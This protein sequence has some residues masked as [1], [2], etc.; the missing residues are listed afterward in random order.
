MKP[1]STS[2][3]RWTGTMS[4]S[5][6]LSN[7]MHR[8]LAWLSKSRRFLCSVP[9]ESARPI[10]LSLWLAAHFWT[11]WK[12]GCY[13]NWIPIMTIILYNL[14][15]LPPPPP[16]SHKCTSASQSCSST[17]L[18]RM[19]C[20]W[21]RHPSPLAT[22]LAGSYTMRFLSLGIRWR[23]RLC[24][25]I[26]HAHPGTLWS[27]NACIASHYSGHATRSLGWVELP[28]GPRCTYWRIITNARE[29]YT[30]AAADSVCCARVSSEIMSLITVETAPFFCACP[31]YGFFRHN[32]RSKAQF[33]RDL[34][35]VWIPRLKPL[36]QDKILWVI[37]RPAVALVSHMQIAQQRQIF[38]A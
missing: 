12:T 19:C 30:V 10:F 2:V 37:V 23:Q 8:T 9:W 13:P 1:R 14:T 15:E 6:E 29:T 3:A 5:G 20:K 26:A 4:V 35:A 21:R 17:A 32:F 24:A 38:H 7:H 11:C 28:C 31:V 25:T 16:F 34:T 18:D 36:K 27:D 33:R 22:P